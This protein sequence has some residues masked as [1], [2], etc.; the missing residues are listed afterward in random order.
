MRSERFLISNKKSNCCNY[1]ALIVKS[2]EGG[3]VSQNCLKCGKPGTVRLEDLPD[4]KCDFCSSALSKE[5]RQKNYFYACPKCKRDWKLADNL[6][7][8]LR[9]FEEEGFSLY[10][11]AID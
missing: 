4:L 2:R 6:P 5:I 1:N 8:W 10:G 9:L 7:H 3:F 11:E